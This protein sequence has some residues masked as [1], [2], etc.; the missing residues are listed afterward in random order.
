MIP[1]QLIEE[2]LAYRRRYRG[3]IG[4][5]SRLAVKDKHMLSVVYTPGVAEPCLRIHENPEL[6]FDLTPRGNTVALVSDGS[7]VFGRGNLG[8]EAA[9]PALEGKAAIFKTFAGV[10]AYPICLRSA[11]PYETIDTLL[12]LAPTFG[13]IVLEDIASPHA[14]TITDHLSRA[15]DIPV[16]NNHQHG[17][18]IGVLAGLQ[19]ALKVVGKALEEV[20]IVVNGAGT[21]GIATAHLLLDAGARHVVVCDRHG[22]LYPYRPVGM[23]WA[24]WEVARRTNPEGEVRGTLAEVLK[25]ADVFIGFS[26][27]GVLTGEMVRTM[28]KDPIVFAFFVPEPEIRPE[29]AKAAGAKVVATARSDYPNEMDIALVF[30]GFLRGVLDVRARGINT[31][32][33][34]AAAQ[35]VAGLV[36][37]A[38][39][40]PDRIVPDPMDLRLGPAVAE[41]VARAAIETGE[42]RV[43]RDP[44]EIA[45]WTRRYVYEGPAAVAPRP[46]PGEEALSFAEEAV[47]VRRRYRGL[48]EIQ[49]KLEIKDKYIFSMYLPPADAVPAQIIAE[50]PEQVYELTVKGNL[51]AVVSDGSAVLGLGNIGGRAALPVMEGKSI[52]FNTFAGVEA[53][54]ICLD[55]Q[56]P[57][58]IIEVVRRLAPT[59]GGIN[60]EDISAP[61]C[62][63]IE[64]KLKELLDI[65]VFHDDQH[66]TAVVTLAG[67]H[68]ALKLTGKKMEDLTIVINGAGAAGVAVTKIL[69]AAGARNI[70]LCDRAGAIYKGRRERMNWIKKEMARITNPEKRKGSLADVLKGADVFIGLSSP[71]VVTQEMVRSMAPD[72][73]IF[74]MANPIPEIMPDE[75]LEAGAAIVATGRSD[76]DNQVNNS[77]AFPGIFRGALDVRARAINE[78]MK[79]AAAEAI[80]GLVSDKELKPNYIL[81]KGTDL[82]VAAYVAEA[83]AR[84]AMETGVA[85]I[86]VDPEEVRRNTLSYVY[87]GI[88]EPLGTGSKV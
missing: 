46:K 80:A 86:K 73:I 50:D 45:E 7:S 36:S 63:Y 1:Q 28:A 4:V 41:A 66:G 34:L 42:A 64:E 29:E 14:L 65:P 38:E 62:F 54:P 82:R 76:F 10:D 68:N 56:D 75:A 61:R 24:K 15:L 51:V 31:A 58:E 32:M 87:E 48:L 59:F 35:A 74:A 12:H 81:P 37:E 23:N 16:F 21:A 25:G 9:L 19:N 67:L 43:E 60:L 33:M 77:L 17:V 52:L 72:P 79:L 53:V 22:A 69:L 83:V 39:L 13:A 2:A 47:E 26:A 57:D 11:S 71:G 6:S 5:T 27:P 40:H 44:K 70:I 8:P 78:A 30:P 88:L 55:T 20:R 84:A 85:R 49:P 18:A 3:A